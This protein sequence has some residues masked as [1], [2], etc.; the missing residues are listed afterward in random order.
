MSGRAG[1]RRPLAALLLL[2]T[3]AVYGY[4]A[5]TKWV[6]PA[7]F[8]LALSGYGFG[9]GAV[10]ALGL[11]VPAGETALALA[12]LLAWIWT[13]R[14]VP[15][16]LWLAAAG[17]VAFTALMSWALATG[18]GVSGC[19]CFGGAEPVGPWDV[20]RDVLFLALAAA[21][22]LLWPKAEADRASPA[23]EPGGDEPAVAPAS[24][25][26]RVG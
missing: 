7:G 9:P 1:L 13:P 5:W 11:A 12:L 4:S 14:R 15:L 22:A 2:A 21:G 26:A 8:A 3:A 6:D 24:R 20:V 10:A 19:G 17:F 16:L 18:R 23:E 25:G